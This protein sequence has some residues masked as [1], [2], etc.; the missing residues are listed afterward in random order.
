MGVWAVAAGARIDRGARG[1][2]VPIRLPLQL[3]D[4]GAPAID[5]E[6]HLQEGGVGREG[7]AVATALFPADECVGAAVGAD[8][9]SD[10]LV[11][12]GR[13]RPEV[14][15]RLE[16]RPLTRGGCEGLLQIGGVDRGPGDAVAGGKAVL[17]GARRAA[18]AAG[19]R[20]VGEDLGAIRHENHAVA[21]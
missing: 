14:G 1:P 15:I 5:G 8:E 4:V 10:V 19:A 13:G 11:V 16:Q 6:G 20:A 17:P 7:P 21:V 3:D 12:A 2:G 9:D 18:G